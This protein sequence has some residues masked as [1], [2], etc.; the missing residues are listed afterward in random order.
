M[1][2]QFVSIPLGKKVRPRRADIHSS[3]ISHHR[4]C[5][6][7]SDLAAQ[8]EVEFLSPRRRQSAHPDCPVF[9]LDRAFLAEQL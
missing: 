9:I 3:A 7:S 1:R 4:A 2:K 6:R 5:G 8:Q